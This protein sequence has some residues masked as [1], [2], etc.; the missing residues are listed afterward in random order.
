MSNYEKDLSEPWFS[1]IKLGIKKVE[2]RLHKGDFA[3]MKVGDSILFT[4]NEFGFERKCRMEIKHISYYD[5]FRSYLENELVER[6]LPG[7]E[8]IEDGLN[9]YYKY[10]KKSDEIKYKIIAFTFSK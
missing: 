1:L 8:N 10:Y 3:N 9:I 6:C 2:G 7:I 5:N 4:N